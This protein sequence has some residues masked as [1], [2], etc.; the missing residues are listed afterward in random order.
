VTRPIPQN[1]SHGLLSDGSKTYPLRD[2]YVTVG[3]I[4]QDW[5]S[6]DGNGNFKFNKD[7]AK[8]QFKFDWLSAVDRPQGFESGPWTITVTAGDE[9]YKSNVI[10][11]GGTEAFQDA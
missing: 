1:Y 8:I 3:C 7:L 6:T 4:S 9:T 2:I 5:L 11:N 10:W